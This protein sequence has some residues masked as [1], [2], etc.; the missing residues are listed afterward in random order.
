MPSWSNQLA[1]LRAAAWDELSAL[2]AR[3]AMHVSPETSRRVRHYVDLAQRPR[4]PLVHVT[5]DEPGKALDHVGHDAHLRHAFATRL[6]AGHESTRATLFRSSL[7]PSRIRALSSA[8]VVLVELER[9]RA[10]PFARDGWLILPRWVKL[11][12]DLRRSDHELWDAK[13]RETVAR[14]DRSSLDA[15]I[16]AAETVCEEFYARFYAPTAHARHGALAYVR[17]RR[18]IERMARGA[19]VLFVRDRG[20]RVAAVLL[21]PRDDVLD[22][23]VVGVRGGE[24]D[25]T[26]L[27]REAVYLFAIRHARASGHRMLGLTSANP[28]LDDG[29]L[30]FKKRWG[31]EASVTSADGRVVAMGLFAATPPLIRALSDSP[32]VHLIDPS[33]T[34]TLTAT[35]IG[36]A[37]TTR[38][39]RGVESA[40]SLAG[41]GPTLVEAFGA[42]ARACVE[43]A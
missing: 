10:E 32:I 36:S 35:T 9:D 2:G 11:A 34:P 19:R 23:L 17:G 37:A 16:V 22:A 39:P 12:V 6:G 33:G 5:A 4:A 13:K 18:F 26:T 38:P 20:E 30:R 43:A 24:Y 41:E 1:G 14:I 25:D 42:R 31:A 8:P 40:L 21:A 27:A 3:L 28:F 7:S 15:E 29:L